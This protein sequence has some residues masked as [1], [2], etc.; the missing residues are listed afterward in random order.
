LLVVSGCLSQRYQQELQKELPEVDLFTGVGDYDKI[1]EI[2][3]KRKSIFSSKT[4]LIDN[5]ERVITNSNFHAYIKL[6]EGCNQVCSFCAIP[7]FK[8]KLISRSIKSVADEVK[9]LV[10]YGFFDFTFISQDSSS[11]LRDFDQKN[12]LIKLIDEIE[13]IDE[14]ISARILYLYPTTTT[15]ELIERIISSKV[16]HNYFDMPIQHISDHM[17]KTMKRGA[18]KKRIIHQLEKMRSAGESFL[19]T[20]VIIGHP[21]ESEEDFKELYNFLKE[22]EFDRINVFAYSDEEDTASY[23][24]KEKVPKDIIEER[25]DKIEN[26]VK[27]KNQKSLQNEVGKSLRLVTTGVSSEGEFFIGSRKLIWAPE[28]DGEILINDSETEEKIQ[29]GKIYEAKITKLAGEKLLA[30]LTKAI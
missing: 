22:F 11:Y 4:Y 27:E 13:K 19:R 7:N 21:R 29:I 20:G 25:L 23:K 6:S 12:G 5:E 15:D 28:I 8:G 1:D 3:N 2:I 26:I 16:F 9:K 10:S 24:M 18:D 30:T 14:V 17:L